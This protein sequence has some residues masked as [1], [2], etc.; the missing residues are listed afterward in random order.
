MRRSTSLNLDGIFFNTADIFQEAE[1]FVNACPVG[2]GASFVYDVPI[3]NGQTGTHWYH[4]ELSVQYVDVSDEK[5][6]KI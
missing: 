5:L 3:I 6:L 1:P 4:S 2:P